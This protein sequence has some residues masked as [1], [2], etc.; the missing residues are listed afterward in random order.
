MFLFYPLVLASLGFFAPPHVVI[1]LISLSFIVRQLSEEKGSAGGSATSHWSVS[2]RSSEWARLAQKQTREHLSR[3][4]SHNASLSELTARVKAVGGA[5][6]LWRLHLSAVACSEQTQK[7]RLD[8]WAV[9]VSTLHTAR[10]KTLVFVEKP[11]G[12]RLSLFWFVTPLTCLEFTLWLDDS[13]F[14]WIKGDRRV[15][16]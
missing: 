1:T 5:A 10:T 3:N 8:V 13:L 14:Y 15:S 7:C 9:K 16:K 12:W 4:F 11:E 2:K 6:S